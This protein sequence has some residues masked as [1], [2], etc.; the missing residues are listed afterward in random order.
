MACDESSHRRNKTRNI[1]LPCRNIPCVVFGF[2]AG[3]LEAT[4]ATLERKNWNHY[5]N[6]GYE[7]CGI[8]SFYCCT[9]FVHLRSTMWQSER[10]YTS[11]RYSFSNYIYSCTW[12]LFVY[13]GSCLTLQKESPNSNQKQG[14]L[15]NCPRYGYN[16]PV[17]LGE[18]RRQG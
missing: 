1:T 4:K 5:L 12:N 10:L 14:G 13:C 17:I 16:H 6:R 3:T 8:P 2:F 18:R 9:I 7:I 15:L 11:Q